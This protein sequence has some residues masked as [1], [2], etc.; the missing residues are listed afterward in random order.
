MEDRL[1]YVPPNDLYRYWDIV[2]P[3]L[4]DCSQYTYDK[5]MPEDVYNALKT[6]VATLHIA[7]DEKGLEGFVVL[8]PINGFRGTRLLVWAIKSFRPC[9]TPYEKYFPEIVELA[10]KINAVGICFDTHRRGWEKGKPI[11]LFGFKPVQ[12]RYEMEV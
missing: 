5:W 8:M 1:I 6:N 3:G 9:K 10:R 4:I 12:T 7:Q 2:R 11:S